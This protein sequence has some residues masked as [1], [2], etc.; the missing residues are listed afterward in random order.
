MQRT[1]LKLFGGLALSYDSVVDYATLYQD[2]RWKR[3]VADR[4]PDGGPGDVLDIGCGTL[5][6][7]ERISSPRLTFVGVDLT[8]EMVRKGQEK[9]LRNVALM[10]NG[11]AE[12]LPFPD[13][14]FGAVV[15][16]YVAKYVDIQRF[17]REIARVSEP[18]ARAI[19][20]DFA[21]PRGAL[22]PFLELYIQA[23]IRGVGLL[24][25]LAK[26]EASFAFRKLPRIVDEAGWDGRVVAAMEGS[27][28]ETL[29]AQRLTG[30]V[31][32]A[33]CG[34]RRSP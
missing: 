29:S 30:G 2:R 1:A 16:C 25:G 20:Y 19:L 23:G 7:E 17:A 13:G 24:L 31:V 15:S 11:D 22:A 28:F 26:V 27:G 32:F 34:R 18:G 10:V 8:R 21:R 14:S 9:R 5:L 6:L 3:W 4:I 33:Y 12:S